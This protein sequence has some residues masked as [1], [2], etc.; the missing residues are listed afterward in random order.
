MKAESSY[1]QPWAQRWHR[2]SPVRYVPHTDTSQNPTGWSWIWSVFQLQ[3]GFDPVDLQHLIFFLKQLTFFVQYLSFL[4]VL[5][6]KVKHQITDIKTKTVNDWS[7]RP[8]QHFF[9]LLLLSLLSVFLPLPLGPDR[10]SAICKQAWDFPWLCI[11]TADWHQL[12]HQHL[13]MYEASADVPHLY[14]KNTN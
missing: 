10:S 6:V 12:L 14:K 4:S 1:L 13:S 3:C 2:R 7:R 5:S 11:P 8:L 9:F